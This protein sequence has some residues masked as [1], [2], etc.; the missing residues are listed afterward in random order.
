L[1]SS[2][3][4]EHVVG[5]EL[6]AAHNHV[7]RTQLPRTTAIGADRTVPYLFAM[8]KEQTRAAHKRSD[9]LRQRADWSLPADGTQTMT[10]ASWSVF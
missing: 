6:H 8:L 4:Q 3:S 2:A 9:G 10:P 5:G 1:L 7:R